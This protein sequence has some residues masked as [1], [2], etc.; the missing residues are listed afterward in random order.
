M[1][2]IPAGP[3]ARARRSVGKHSWLLHPITELGHSCDSWAKENASVPTNDTNDT[4]EN[5]ALMLNVEIG[6]AEPRNKSSGHIFRLN[7]R[8]SKKQAALKSMAV[9]RNSAAKPACFPTNAMTPPTSSAETPQPSRI[10]NT[11]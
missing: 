7:F 4:N 1:D 11:V 5:L 8:I 9:T 2:L 10:A 3:R 6:P